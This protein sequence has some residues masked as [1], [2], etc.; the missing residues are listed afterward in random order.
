MKSRGSVRI[1]HLYLRT[2]LGVKLLFLWLF[3]GAGLLLLQPG[4]RSLPSASCGQAGRSLETAGRWPLTPV[5]GGV[6]NPTGC[7][8][9]SGNMWSQPPKSNGKFQEGRNPS[10]SGQ[11]MA[12]VWAQNHLLVYL[13]TQSI[14]PIPSENEKNGALTQK[15][16][17]SWSIRWPGYHI[18]HRFRT[19]CVS[20]AT[21]SRVFFPFLVLCV[22]FQK[23]LKCTCLHRS[24]SHYRARNRLGVNIQIHLKGIFSQWGGDACLAIAVLRHSAR[25]AGGDG[26][27]SAELLRWISG[28]QRAQ[29]PHLLWLTS[30][31]ETT[32][33]KCTWAPRLPLPHWIP[34]YSPSH[35]LSQCLSSCR[36]WSDSWGLFS[37]RAFPGEHGG[38]Q[39]AGQLIWE[40]PWPRE[41]LACPALQCEN[42][43][44]TP[45]RHC[46]K[47]HSIDG[48]GTRGVFEKHLKGPTSW[49]TVWGPGAGVSLA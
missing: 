42:C 41:A 44:P 19:A 1:L 13:F 49:S 29:V 15:T 45:Q 3:P 34:G 32:Q 43:C 25:D 22:C 26:R 27:M 18:I 33:R 21:Q 2:S 4:P 35:P 14:S 39:T 28:W 38:P 10:G 24:G 9:G 16:K 23:P 30:S 6:P 37:L 40:W 31:L 48:P 11:W 7:R 46:E 47:I 8:G 20:R 12:E 36:Q 5:F 17:N